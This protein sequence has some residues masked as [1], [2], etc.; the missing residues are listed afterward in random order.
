MEKILNV[1]EEVTIYTA[2]TSD[3]DTAK[4]NTIPVRARITR[5]WNKP[6]LD[7]Y[8]TVKTVEGGHTY[9]RCISEVHQDAQ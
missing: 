4:P 3:A 6:L 1:E 2:D 7:P 9:T 5:V 8:V